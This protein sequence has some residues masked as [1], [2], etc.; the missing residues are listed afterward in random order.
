M[1]AAE[2]KFHQI[3]D[4]ARE[5]NPFYAE[6]LY[7]KDSVPILTR[8][9]LLENND[10]ILNG[11]PVTAT[12]SGSTGMPVRISMSPDRHSLSQKINRRFIQWLGGPMIRSQIIYPRDASPG[13]SSTADAIWGSSG[14]WASSPKPS[15][16]P[17]GPSSRAP[18]PTR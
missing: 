17:S 11:H 4:H 5:T 8:R 10:R 3:V 13:P 12:T 14:G 2:A 16:R 18:S 9:T 1:T 7:G 6:W 15:I